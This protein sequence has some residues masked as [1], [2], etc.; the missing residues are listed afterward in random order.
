MFQD[1]ALATREC[2]V[3]GTMTPLQMPDRIRSIVVGHEL[4]IVSED[5][6]VGKTLYCRSFYDGTQVA[7]TWSLTS[8]SQYA[9][10]NENG[11]V[12]VNSGV[13]QK[14]IGVRCSYNQLTAQK[15][16]LVSY[17]NQLSIECDNSLVGTSATILA[18]YNQ[19]IVQPQWS[20]MEGSSIAS[21]ASD[22]TLTITGTGTVTIEVQYQGYT[23]DKTISVEYEPNTSSETVVNEDGSI[24]TTTETTIENP[25]GSTTTETTSTTTN[26]DGYFVK[27]K[28]STTE[29]QD[30]SSETTS[31]TTNQDGSYSETTSTTTAPD[32]QG[33]ITT[34][35]QTTNYDE[36]GDETGSQTY[37]SV[38]N[39]DGSSQ[40]TTT[41]YN[42]AGNP[43]D[44]LNEDVDT[45]GNVSD[46]SI[47][48]DSS[49]DPV[50]TG[51]SIDTSDNPE[52]S[53]EFDMDGVNTQFYGFDAV[54]GFT[55]DFHFTFDFTDQPPNQDEKLNNI[56]TM[57]RSNPSPWYGF[58]LRY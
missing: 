23:T 31:T 15:S 39:S 4:T 38:D 16:I 12:D 36:N 40:R 27:T 45:S 47:V 2:G 18:R 25:D 29:N 41:N 17:D 54:T 11:R 10:I 1:I 34:N 52:G 14:T 51:Y 57:K 58:Q 5:E 19:E 30:G 37:R 26:E 20:L 43:T 49:G 28:S 55:L 24:T 35:A 48:Y 44:T 53:K 6:F 50:V 46:Q 8:G 33:S 7:A 13:Q 22:G 21:I 3:V 32:Q 56:L 9:T 42:E